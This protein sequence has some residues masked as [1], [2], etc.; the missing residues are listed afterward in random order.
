MEKYKVDMNT[1]V[2]YNT[3]RHIFNTNK[4][5]NRLNTM[6][7]I[8]I[9]HDKAFNNNFS[10]IPIIIYKT[11]K[12]KDIYDNLQN[13]IKYANYL[14]YYGLS[15]STLKIKGEFFFVDLVFSQMPE[16]RK[17]SEYLKEIILQDTSNYGHVITDYQYYP[18]LIG[19]YNKKN[20]II[21]TVKH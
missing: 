7:N 8:G 3:V 20:E 4:K 2:L 10:V 11:D 6:I 19:S 21:Q 15:K 1:A 13:N 12:P 14:Y 5:I 17:F 18:Y 16:S 9:K